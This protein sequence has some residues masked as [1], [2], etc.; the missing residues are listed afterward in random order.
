MVRLRRSAR[1]S[2][3]GLVLALAAA[4]AQFPEGTAVPVRLKTKVSTQTSHVG[5][6]VEA[7]AIGAGLSGA[8]VR[9][10][11]AKVAASTKGDER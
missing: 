2:A 3:A 5:D 11:V 8:I 9:G 4:A 7:V 6:P 10:K 1:S